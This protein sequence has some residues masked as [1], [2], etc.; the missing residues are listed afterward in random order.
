MFTKSLHLSKFY[1][2]KSFKKNCPRN[3][4]NDARKSAAEGKDGH[5]VGNFLHSRNA[6]GNDYLSCVVGDASRNTDA[7]RWEFI[8]CNFWKISALLKA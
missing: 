5:I 8:Q 6:D 3:A 4:D 1:L 2:F 7:H